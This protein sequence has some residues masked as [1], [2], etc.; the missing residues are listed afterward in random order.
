MID[1][2][3]AI[4][5]DRQAQPASMPCWRHKWST[6]RNWRSETGLV[7]F[8]KTVTPWP[9]LDLHQVHSGIRKAEGKHP[10][11]PTHFH[12]RPV[13]EQNFIPLNV[14]LFRITAYDWGSLPAREHPPPHTHTHTHART[15]THRHTHTHTHM[16]A[17]THTHTHTHTHIHTPTHIHTRARTHAHTHTHTHAR[18]HAHAHTHARTPPPPTPPPPHTHTHT[19]T[20]PPRNSPSACS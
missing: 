3:W 4:S 15:H 5:G 10:T 1:R 8:H 14:F 11:I 16:H 7:D 20:T 18:K 17:H 19:H 6:F 12:S 2:P 13:L 9:P